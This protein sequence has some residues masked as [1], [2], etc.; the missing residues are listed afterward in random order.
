MSY[1]TIRCKD[2]DQILD[3]KAQ[4]YDKGEVLCVVCNYKR[5]GEE[6]P[7]PIKK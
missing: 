4:Y 7:K 2:C 1:G 3:D 5:G 6:W